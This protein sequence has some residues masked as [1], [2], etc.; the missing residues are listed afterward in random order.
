MLLKRSRVRRTFLPGAEVQPSDAHVLDFAGPVLLQQLLRAMEDV[1]APRS[2]AITFA[3][4]SLLV[5]LIACQSSVFSLWF[6]RRC[7]E[8]SRG[9]MITMLYEKTLTRKLIGESALSHKVDTSVNG[10][11][12][13]A[14]A[15]RF[16]LKVVKRVANALGKRI[17]R[18]SSGEK[19]EQ[20]ASIG[21]I[22]NLMR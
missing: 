10:Q 2:K 20:S 1:F 16:G 6:S 12:S 17:W 11:T 14:P 4:L 18:Q 22:Y 7:Y 8:R 3:A 13:D 5:R 21:K 19:V 15:T 9:E